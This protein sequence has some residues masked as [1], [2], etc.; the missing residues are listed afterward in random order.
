MRI[1]SGT[2]RGRTIVAPA[3]DRTRPTQDKVRES[4]FNIIRWDMM[5]ARILDLFAGTGAL[6]LES[7]S[8]GAQ[9]A[10][11]V[12]TDRAACEAIRKNIAAC[13]MEDKARLIVRDYRQ[14]MDQLAREGEVFD[15]VFLDPPY[16]MENTGEMCAALYDKGLLAK[17]FLLVVEHKR[18]LA[19]LVDE[20]FDAFD[21]RDYGDTQITFIRS[22]ERDQADEAE[23][24]ANA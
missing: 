10:V 1:I 2:A 3:G 9:S 21:Q 19:P 20:R 18:G 4:L 22:A 5:E 17:A 7:L 8:R 15:V 13:R 14:A 16:R 24:G 11:L 23:G 12:D 6:S